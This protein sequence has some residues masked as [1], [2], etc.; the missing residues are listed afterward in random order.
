MAKCSGNIGVKVLVSS[1]NSE[2][3]FMS[4]DSDPECAQL[5]CILQWQMFS[6][7]EALCTDDAKTGLQFSVSVPGLNH[8]VV[9]PIIV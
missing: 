9:Q 8:I 4:N 3:E 6:R 1:S 7:N 2:E 5:T